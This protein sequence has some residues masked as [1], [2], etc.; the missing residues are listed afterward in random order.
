MIKT[1]D[2]VAKLNMLNN[3]ILFW[4]LCDEHLLFAYSGQ[5]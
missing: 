4:E 5:D 2:D 1:S 3:N